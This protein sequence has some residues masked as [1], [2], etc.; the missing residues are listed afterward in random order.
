MFALVFIE[1]SSA[2]IQHFNMSNMTTYECR[3]FFHDDGYPATNYL[4]VPSTTVTK[5]FSIHG[6]PGSP[7]TMTFSPAPASCQI[8]L[9]DN[10]TF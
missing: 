10:I 1:K 3:G 7:I 9:G 8:Q 4:S 5:V 2:Q 6:T